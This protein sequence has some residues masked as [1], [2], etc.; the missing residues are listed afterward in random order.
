MKK[1]LAA[2]CVLT[3]GLLACNISRELTLFITIPIC[4]SHRRRTDDAGSRKRFA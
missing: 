2:T 1:L 3:L 4:D